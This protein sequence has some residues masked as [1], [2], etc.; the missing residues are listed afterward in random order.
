[1]TEQKQKQTFGWLIYWV[2]DWYGKQER[3]EFLFSVEAATENEAI[4]AGYEKSGKPRTAK[5][6]AKKMGVRERAKRN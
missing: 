3:S 6:I 5:L 4:D 2:A 1:M